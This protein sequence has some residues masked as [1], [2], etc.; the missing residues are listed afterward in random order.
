[1]DLLNIIKGHA[2]HYAVQTSYLVDFGLLQ[3]LDALHNI[4][5]CRNYVVRQ[6]KDSDYKRLILELKRY[7]SKFF[8]L[9]VIEGE[10]EGENY[11]WS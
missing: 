11:K 7:L 9:G 1:M 8:L 3:R 10:E 5:G 4:V 6:T 2:V